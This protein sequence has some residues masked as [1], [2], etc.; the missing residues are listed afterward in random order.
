MPRTYGFKQTLTQPKSATTE[1]S[2]PKEN[3]HSDEMD[4]HE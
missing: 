4:A 2:Q 3:H 1:G